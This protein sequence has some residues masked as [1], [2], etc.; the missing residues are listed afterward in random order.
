MTLGEQCGCTNHTT[1]RMVLFALA[2]ISAAACL[3]TEDQA[4]QNLTKACEKG[5]DVL[6]VDYKAGSDDIQFQFL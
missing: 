2:V 1:K 6:C 5:R 4:R 3:H